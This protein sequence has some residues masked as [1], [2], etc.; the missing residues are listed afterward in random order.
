MDS[1]SAEAR[2]ANMSKISSRNT[3]PELAI[4]QAIRELGYTGYRLNRTDLPGKP[5]VAFVGR[6]LA[7]FV[8]GC[9]WHGH[10]CKEGKRRPKSNQQYWLPKIAANARR[11]IESHRV[12]RQRGWRVLTIWECE[13][14]QKNAV[15]KRLR[16]FL[17]E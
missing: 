16:A 7:I 11:D 8:N 4:R 1:V 12:L 5:D 14:S 17:S 2:S 10:N 15:R 9:F 3:V 6:K 13:I